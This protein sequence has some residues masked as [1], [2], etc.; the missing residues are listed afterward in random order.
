VE[1]FVGNGRATL[2]W[3][4]PWLAGLTAGAIAP[5]LIKLIKSVLRKRQSIR[6]GLANNAWV[7]DIAGEHSVDATVQ[8]LRLWDAVR[9]AAIVCDEGFGNDIFRWK[10]SGDGSFSSHTAYMMLFHGTIGF[11]AAPL[12][13]ASF[14]PLKHRFH[15][16]L[17]LR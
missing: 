7:L 4:D 2:F 16:W 15:A 6:E 14:A 8:Y 17:A 5:V 11:T 3:E 10:W 1:I 13:W 9:A 12:I